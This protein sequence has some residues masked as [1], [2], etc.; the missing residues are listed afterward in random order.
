M[1]RHIPKT[2]SFQF[3]S[4]HLSEYLQSE[5]FVRT[6]EKSPDTFLTF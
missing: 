3:E 5:S 2:L 6:R 1:Y 4:G